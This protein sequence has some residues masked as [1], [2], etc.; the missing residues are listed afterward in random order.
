VDVSENRR[1]VC[2]HYITA[3]C[4]CVQ[5]VQLAGWQVHASDGPAAARNLIE[6]HAIRVGLVLLSGVEPDDWLFEA[7]G[8]FARQTGTEWVAVISPGLLDRPGMRDFIAAYFLDYHTLPV[9]S[10]RLLYSLGHALGMASL[11]TSIP[12]ESRDEHLI[13][14]SVPMRQLDAVLDKVGKVDAPLLVT[15][16]TGTGKELAVTAI[17]AASARHDKPLI[18]VN[19]AELPPTLIHAELFGYEKG[20]FTGAVKRKLGY[21]E[22]ANG[23]T[24]FLDEIGDL[25][26]DLQIL[27][28]RFLQEKVIRRVGGTSDIC[29]DARVI[30][31]THVNLRATVQAGRFREDLFHRLNVLHIHMPALRERNG[32]IEL[33]A[34]HFMEKFSAESSIR[35]RGFSA[36]ALQAMQRYDWPGNVREL[37]NRVRR[38]LV[39]C[40][41]QVISAASLGIPGQAGGEACEQLLTLEEARTRAERAAAL[42]ALAHCQG[43]T[44]AAAMLLDVSRATFYRLL[45]RNG[46]SADSWK[47][48]PPADSAAK[49]RAGGAATAATGTQASAPL[50]IG[51]RKLLKR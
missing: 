35:I 49:Q 14:N 27:L 7:R 38:A 1:L 43:N 21:I 22:Q 3:D 47:D 4:S 51:R 29:V 13:G 24:I 5:A 44:S 26:I 50:P 42:A 11:L 6:S 48:Q 45:E 12:I 25:G 46:L 17:H 2:L 37:M 16:E 41:G 34:Q 8:L 9:D 28:L 19:C 40:N 23:G 31:A 32:D 39:M 15:G 20:A 18:I 36:S 10:D 30:A 33:L